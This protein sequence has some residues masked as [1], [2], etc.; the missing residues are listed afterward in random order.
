[1][2]LKR[3]LTEDE[4]KKLLELFK[5]KELKSDSKNYYHCENMK[6][7]TNVKWVNKTLNEIIEGFESFTK[8]VNKNDGSPSIR[9]Q[10]NYGYDDTMYFVGVG[11]I[12]IDNLKNGFT[13]EEKEA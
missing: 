8:F 11:Y 6:D 3:F 2:K 4:Y 9:L 1:M 13:T 12:T 10:Y 7:D 5:Y